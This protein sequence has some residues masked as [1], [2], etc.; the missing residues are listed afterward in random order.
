MQWSLT[1]AEI[2]DWLGG[3]A[4]SG[5][6]AGPITRI[7]DLRTA[8]AG[9]LSFLGS[10]KYEKHLAASRAGVVLVPLDQPGG[11]APGQAWIRVADP[12]LALAQIC[13]RLE[14]QL[15]PPPEPGIHPAA[16]IDPAAEVDPTAAVGPFC[17]VG[18]GA[19][20]GAGAVLQSHVRVERAAVVGEGSILHHGVVI[21]WGCRVGRHCRLFPGVVIGA[22]GF[23]YHSDSNGHRRLPQIGI[24]VIEDHVDIGANSTVDRARFAETRIGAG[25][26]IDNL[27]QIGHNVTIG[28]HCILCAQTGIA[29][30]TEL[31]DFV[32]LGGQVGVNGHIKVGDG[33]SATA[34]SGISKDVPPGVVL[35]G[36]PA[37]PHREEMRR[38]AL[39]KQIPALQERLRALEQARAT[40]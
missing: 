28:R 1:A 18:P 20:I 11:P 25:T 10:A 17:L 21:G 2:A 15:V 4:V 31:G 16:L 40:P 7:A 23:G 37:R 5:S 26:K 22:D 34:Q 19:R 14:R 24:V 36:S 33:V 9:D 38:H 27:V 3:A 35:S 8:E 32:V 29:G 6:H 13:A 30:S 39:V 12:S